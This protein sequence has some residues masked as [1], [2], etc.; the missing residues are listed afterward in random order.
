MKSRERKDEAKLIRSRLK[1]VGAEDHHNAKRTW[2]RRFGGRITKE[3]LD[4]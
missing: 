1:E 3:D 2:T 4:Y